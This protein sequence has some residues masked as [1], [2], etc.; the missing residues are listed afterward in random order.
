MNIEKLLKAYEDYKN[1]VDD[2]A[3]DKV[4][5][6]LA[7][8]IHPEKYITEQTILKLIERSEQK[9]N[10]NLENIKDE[11]KIIAYLFIEDILGLNINI[12]NKVAPLITGK[13]NYNAEHFYRGVICQIELKYIHL[14]FSIYDEI[15]NFNNALTNLSK[16]YVCFMY[17]NDFTHKK[18][19][20][21]YKPD[22]VFINHLSLENDDNNFLFVY[23]NIKELGKDLPRLSKKLDQWFEFRDK[24]YKD[25]K[26][27]K[28][29]TEELNKDPFF[30]KKDGIHDVQYVYSFWSNTSYIQNIKYRICLYQKYHEKRAYFINIEQSIYF[31]D[32]EYTSD[33]DNIKINDLID[34]IKLTNGKPY[35][36]EITIENLPSSQYL[37]DSTSS[38]IKRVIS[39]DGSIRDGNFYELTKQIDENIVLDITDSYAMTQDRNN[40]GQ[41]RMGIVMSIFYFDQDFDIHNYLSK[42]KTLYYENVEHY[43]CSLSIAS[44][45]DFY[46]A[47]DNAVIKDLGQSNKEIVKLI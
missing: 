21:V 44:K 39:K 26:K 14:I 33:L 46:A 23:D 22:F 47:F 19:L 29:L 18:Y 9:K 16:K 42:L 35:E 12:H 6:E 15:N 31:K 38:A 7:N 27:Y 20:R 8:S 10:T 24:M 2:D 34:N 17:E 32:N 30:A 5:Q 3:E 4:V 37:M 41:G 43:Q 25:I 40:N 45:E 1:A 11:D 28:E 13:I 36:Y